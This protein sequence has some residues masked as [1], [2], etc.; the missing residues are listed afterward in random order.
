MPECNF[1]EKKLNSDTCK[2]IGKNQLYQYG[3]F[4]DTFNRDIT[5]F[6]NKLAFISNI[7]D[8]P[9]E[10]ITLETKCNENVSILNLVNSDNKLLA[11]MLAS[12]AS[13][14]YEMSLIIEEAEEM[15]QHFV[16]LEV[17][18]QFT[19]EKPTLNFIQKFFGKLQKTSSIVFRSQHVIQLLLSQLNSLV[20]NGFYSS[21]SGS[22]FSESIDHLADLL[23]C[24]IVI[25]NLLDSPMIR[26]YFGHYLI[27]VKNLMHDHRKF[28]FSTDQ[29]KFLERNIQDVQNMLLTGNI[30]QDITSYCASTCICFPGVASE[31]AAHI[32]EILNELDHDEDS[33]LFTQL[34][35]QANAL[36]AFYCSLYGDIEKK[37][38]KKLLEV[39]RK[40]NFCTLAGKR[41]WYSDEF[42][43]KQVPMFAKYISAQNL[44]MRINTLNSK[45]LNIM[46]E[47]H[48][49]ALQASLCMMNLERVINQDM[50]AV[51]LK[52]IHEATEI[53]IE[54]M[55]IVKKTN[56]LIKWI[57]GLHALHNVPIGKSPL[58]AFCRLIEIL[59]CFQLLLTK[60]LMPQTYL[61]MLLSQHLTYKALSLVLTAKKNLTQDKSYKQ[62]QLD[63]IS[64]LSICEQAIK[65]PNTRDRLLI[66]KLALSASG[67]SKDTSQEIKYVINRLQLI[68]SIP[69][70]FS[71][72]LNCSFLYE[73]LESLIPTYFSKLLE[74]KADLS[75]FY[76]MVAAFD[77][78]SSLN[79]GAVDTIE[80][81]IKQNFLD[82][83]IQNVETN[84]R[85][86][87]HLHLVLP[88]S[89]PFS[90][91]IFFNFSTAAP[92]KLQNNLCSTKNETEHYLS[93]MF[94]NLTTVVLHDW[95]TYGEMRRLA[96]LQY[97]LETI[98]D[99]L[100]MQRI[101]QGLDVLEIM[102][103]INVFVSKY[104]YNLN[105]QVFVEEKSTNKHLN[106]INISHIA[107]SIRTHGVGI[108]N[109][110]VNFTYQFLQ[111][112]FF[113]FSQF[114]FDEQIKSRLLKDLKYFHT[115]KMEINQMYPYER[116]EK[117]NN[118]IKKLGLNENGQSYLD[119]FRKLISHIGN[120][121]GYVRL[122]RSGGRRCL[123]EGTCFI[124]DLKKIEHISS[125]IINE[126]MP[127]LTKTA[128][129]KFDHELNI[130][131]DNFEEATEYFKLL[132]NVFRPI[133]TDTKNV[134]LKNFFI[135]IPALTINFVENTITCK[136]RL[137]K[138][139]NDAAF[140]DDGFAM[141]LA[142]I[143]ELLEQEGN[144]DSLHWFHSVKNKLSTQ[145]KNVLEQR[146]RENKDDDKLQQTLSLTERRIATYEREFQLLYCNYKSAR[147]FFQS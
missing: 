87:T 16:H 1:S 131:L 128:K 57:L 15:Y 3:V 126:N 12:L 24:L 49:L 134:H 51:D 141:G 122:I 36:I 96:S 7:F 90:N 107:N 117:F 69:S 146:M 109:T 48:A 45:N 68:N 88:P 129:S 73:H 50:T 140:T 21:N 95:Q 65:G 127:D 44:S 72:T 93:T 28:S 91:Y 55:K 19:Y 22:N 143:I 135:I 5:K 75:R 63:V 64:G 79:K 106:T 82:P 34:W 20:G 43:L 123:A 125:E 97:N 105:S 110:T 60:N 94:Y 67:I 136:E 58:L 37:L 147:I 47:S 70:L 101:E 14:C 9:N 46:K 144:F 71:E 145:K 102:R 35:L 116:A 59:K 29:L 118:G 99:N 103:N 98:E 27:I 25:E 40:R 54:A 23:V 33:I 42:L 18:N 121:M 119:L 13:I 92:I 2:I 62:K 112:K 111:K 133:F 66:A 76:L 30:F 138:N 26:Q 10:L 17:T 84:L 100:P 139:R 80:E 41:I 83:L 56:E 6:K 115:N 114:M 77:D 137:N 39:N 4:S 120:A 108:M 81:F 124:P 74:N 86:Q 61:I 104:L 130:L 78:C 11:K 53:I 32:T 89:D 38:A 31:F 85:L 132:V 8:D 113:I 52:N 142:F